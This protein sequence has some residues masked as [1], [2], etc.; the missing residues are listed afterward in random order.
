MGMIC[1]T[2]CREIESSRQFLERLLQRDGPIK[3]VHFIDVRQSMNNGGGPACLRLRVVLNDAEAAATAPGVFLTDA[4]TLRS[5]AG[6]IAITAIGFI[7]MIWPTPSC[8]T[9]AE[10]RWTN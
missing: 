10:P 7:L 1:P 4:L 3:A 9:K 8:W 2:E 5:V 6:S